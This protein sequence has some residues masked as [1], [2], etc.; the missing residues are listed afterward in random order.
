MQF[1]IETVKGS[2]YE[3]GLQHGRAYRHVIIGNVHVFALRHSFQGA[4]DELDAALAPLRASNEHF[5][6][7]VFEELRGI[8]EGSGVPLPHIVRMHLRV[9]NNVPCKELPA[10]SSGCTGIGFIGDEGVI[11]GGTLDDPRQCEVLLRRLP[12]NGI[13]HIQV[14]WAGVGWGHNGVNAAG[15]FVAQSSVGS[16]T[17]LLPVIDAGPRLHGSMA[18]RIL[19]ETCEDV[20]QALEALERL[21]SSD[22]FVLAD[23]RGNLVARQS[24]GGLGHALQKPSEHENFVFNTN[25]VHMPGMVQKVLDAGCVPKLTEYSMTRFSVLERARKTMPRSVETMEQLLRSHA[26]YPHCICNDGTV[27]ASYAIPQKRPGVLFLADAPP[28]RNA[29]YEYAVDEA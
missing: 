7:W 22:N 20:P 13:G 17:P 25:H 8:A 27:T 24:L 3:M 4:D 10:E 11:V 9:W 29:F 16:T 6:P 18:S 23:A 15:L 26:G 1:P 5:A 2:H 19:L 21:N 28:C 14:T 12:E